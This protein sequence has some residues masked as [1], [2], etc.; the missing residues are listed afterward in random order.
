M[1]VGAANGQG[2]AI[3]FEPETVL[4]LGGSY[5]ITGRTP[6]GPFRV[7]SPIAPPPDTRSIVLE[8]DACIRVTP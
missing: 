8:A 4:Y 3:A 6:L 7:L 5:E 2:T 1:R